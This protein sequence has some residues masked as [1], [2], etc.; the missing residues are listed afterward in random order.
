MRSPVV[1]ERLQV[2][3]EWKGSPGASESVAFLHGQE[4]MRNL[5]YE[6]RVVTIGGLK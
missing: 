4:I 1:D 5:G 3:C 6:N 2:R